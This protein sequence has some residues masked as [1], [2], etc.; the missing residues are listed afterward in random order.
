MLKDF[1]GRGISISDFKGEDAHAKT[2]AAMVAAM[3]GN[4]A[5]KN[6]MANS[7]VDDNGRIIDYTRKDDGSLGAKL[8]A[9][10]VSAFLSGTI[11]KMNQDLVASLT[12]YNTQHAFNKDMQVQMSEDGTQMLGTDEA[13]KGFLQHLRNKQYTEAQIKGMLG[14]AGAT[15]MD[16]F[17]PENG[18]MA[19]EAMFGVVGGLAA[20]ALITKGYKATKNL[21]SGKNSKSDK[22]TVNSSGNNSYNNDSE[23]PNPETHGNSPKNNYEF[24]QTQINESRTNLE[25][26]NKELS[27]VQGEKESLHSQIYNA[28]HDRKMPKAKRE[29]IIARANEQLEE[30]GREEI[31]LNTAISDVV[32]Y[33]MPWH[34][35]FD[36]QEF[37]IILHL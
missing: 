20:G 19:Q 36:I 4:R 35:T 37:A 17:S 1:E 2:G 27:Q 21:L 22:Q 14:E 15:F 30:L 29:D 25:N 9:D 7:A 33:Y 5:K 32:R 6:N 34:V 16:Q 8:T 28:K 11:Y 23:K 10:G 24:A 13:K 12:S 26:Y 3:A 18:E 31:R